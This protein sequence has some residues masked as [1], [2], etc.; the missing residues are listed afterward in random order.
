M[1]LKQTFRAEIGFLRAMGLWIVLVLFA[2]TPALAQVSTATILGVVQDT[3]G[4][5]VP[6]VTVTV[7]NVNTGF[8]RTVETDGAGRYRASQLAVGAYEVQAVLPGFRTVVMSGITLNVGREAV[9]DLTLEVGA[10]TEQVTVT[11]EAPLVESTTSDVTANLDVNQMSNLPLVGRDWLSMTANAPGV[12][13]SGTGTPTMGAQ[14]TSRTRILVDGKKIDDSTNMRT[15]NMEYS[16]EAIR[17]VKVISSRMSAEFANASGGVVSAVTK[18]GT[19]NLDGSVFG[20]FRDGSLNAT[21]FFTDTKPEFSNKVVGGTIG[22]PIVSDKL[23]FF[24]NIEYRRRSQTQSTGTGI[25]EVDVEYPVDFKHDIYFL[26]FDYQ[27]SQNHQLNLRGAYNFKENLNQSVSDHTS[28][29][30]SFPKQSWQAGFQLTSVVGARGVNNFGYQYFPASFHR[31]LNS[32]FPKLIFPAAEVGTNTNSFYSQ[33]ERYNQIH[34]NFIYSQGDHTLKLGAQFD[35][36]NN[37]GYF[38]NGCTG[39]FLF[40]E[41]PTDWAAVMQVINNKDSVLLQSLVDQG[42]VPIPTR[43]RLA[44]GDDT[45]KTPQRQ[46]GIYFNDDWKVTP[47]LTLNLGLRYDADFGAFYPQLRSRFVT[48]AKAPS[49]DTNNIAPRLGFAFD[50]TGEGRAV[51]RGGAGRFYDRI[52]NNITFAHKVF[53]GDTLVQVVTFPGDPPRADFMIN[54]LGG[55][56]TTE[57]VIAGGAITDIR[58]NA[59]NIEVPYTDQVTLGVSAELYRNVG[60]T[61]D[62]VHIVGQKEHAMVDRNV[63]CNP[64]T[65]M[66]LPVLEFGRPDPRYNAINLVDSGGHSRYEALQIGI[67]RRMA[68]NFQFT[69]S[70]NLSWSRANGTNLH[71]T[72][73]ASRGTP[74]NRE[75]LWGVSPADQRHRVNFNFVYGLPMGFQLSSVVFAGS[76]QHFAI[77]SGRDLDGDLQNRDL[78]VNPDGT[79]MPFAGGVSDSMFR[80]DLRVSKR[81]NFWRG[82]DDKQIEFL[83]EFFNLFNRENYDPRRYEGRQSSRNFLQPRRSTDLNFQPFQMQLGFRF[84]F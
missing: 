3:T 65:G 12:R 45:F 39:S 20:F 56:T 21:D 29:G 13:N 66:P 71:I 33:G 35:Y 7:K 75:L 69:G 16:Q 83:A 84:L 6:G 68:D 47:Q 73:G 81:F 70:Y 23:F 59:G 15:T 48:D 78:A 17:E 26:R 63:F 64:E 22:G 19:N 8:T 11:G 42:I 10:T 55:I 32:G 27:L 34:D 77:T 31:K 54:P 61:A 9:I 38:C 43:A 40:D 53:N 51:I 72:S 4:A 5:V 44:F 82:Q 60:I 36:E 74:C 49:D 2:S 62:F 67:N 1:T 79:P 14:T 80:V 18:S 41:D 57:E 52:N 46:L 25:P 58:P 37:V 28:N 76:G 50:P 30:W 24:G